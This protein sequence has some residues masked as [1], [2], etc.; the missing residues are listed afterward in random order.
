MYFPAQH[1]NK[2]ILHLLSLK[3]TTSVIS[4]LTCPAQT[5][6]FFHFLFLL[7]KRTKNNN[8]ITA[9]RPAWRSIDFQLL[10]HHLNV[11]MGKN[12]RDDQSCRRLKV[13][14]E[15]VKMGRSI[16]HSRLS[17]LAFFR[18]L[19]GET[20][21]VGQGACDA[22][23]QAAK[24]GLMHYW[25]HCGSLLKEPLEFNW[26][27]LIWK[28]FISQFSLAAEMGMRR[29]QPCLWEILDLWLFQQRAKKGERD[30]V[31]NHSELPFKAS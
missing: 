13:W 31:P 30:A 10:C 8:N 19:S 18:L 16:S 15:E 3:C 9:Q 28:G 22:T 2:W 21:S 23:R 20:G 7:T 17:S 11:P 6:Q 26:P 14:N 12:T 24:S 4:F 29:K 25:T 1:Q 5:E 27:Q